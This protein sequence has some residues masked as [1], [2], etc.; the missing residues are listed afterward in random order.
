[1]SQ[2]GLMRRRRFTA[3]VNK[4]I[5]QQHKHVPPALQNK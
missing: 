1:M 4:I 3:V 5:S 2:M